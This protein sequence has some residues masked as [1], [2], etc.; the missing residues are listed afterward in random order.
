M[1]L[2]GANDP[3]A[4]HQPAGASAQGLT[5]F[6]DDFCPTRSEPG[7]CPSL[8]SILS[9]L[10]KM[11]AL[12][13][14]TD[15]DGAFTSLA[16][17]GLE[18]AGVVP[19]HYA[20]QPIEALF[21]AGR[22]GTGPRHAHLKALLGHAA[23]FDT[24][25]NGRELQ[26]H[27]E[28]LRDAGGTI[29]GVI[30]VALDLTERMAA[31]RAL[32]V[33]EQSYRSLIQEAPY[34]MC[35]CTLDGQLL[36]VNRAMVELLGY[37]ASCE[38]ELLVRDLDEIFAGTF[39]TL[40]N[41][42]L[43]EGTVN[44]METGWLPRDGD[45]VQV[46]VSGRAFRDRTGAITLLDIL[47]QNVTDK[48]RLEEHLYQAHK[49]QAI[50]QLA[51]GVAHDFNNLLTVIGGQV[52]LILEEAEDPLLRKRL[53]RIQQASERASKLTRQLLAYSR[54]QVMQTKVIP[55][56]EVIHHLLDLLSRLVKENVE[57]TFH[58]GHDLG[59]VRADPHQLEQVLINLTINAQDAMP[60]G[61]LLTLET[62]NL[63][64]EAQPAWSKEPLPPGDYVQIIV[65]DTGHGMAP[66]LQE[67]VFEPFF[68]TKH[69]GEGTGLG[70]SMAYGIVTQ[71]GGTISLAS[72]PGQGCTFWITLPRTSRPELE[73]ATQAPK[74][75]IPKG[76]ETILLAEDEDALRSLVTGYLT[77]LGYR[78]LE[79]PDGLAALEAA[80]NH[81]GGIHLLLTDLVM[82][83]AGGRML[84]E[85]MLKDDPELKVIF[86]S[87][88]AGHEVSRE[89]LDLPF[90]HFVAK[91][92]SMESLARTV[93]TV[94]DG[95]G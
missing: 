14:A 11:P 50:G 56:N 7:R 45:L 54:R 28:P 9:L 39:S 64:L 55:L 80:R 42:L 16:G 47:A 5:P 29:L 2:D 19:S 78:V 79:A 41:A 31:E 27:L 18:A 71:S 66:A 12:L 75:S 59:W 34:A 93:R 21:P 63:R 68:T 25:V 72:T 35:R 22:A 52:E 48:K 38:S 74:A 30:G 62:R 82:P 94:L 95:L 33:S 89:D 4:L 61:G 53:A 88:Y 57:L 51:G 32:R 26:A 46:V 90:G 73:P 85:E 36:Q 69:T 77:R 15:A 49:M 24:E 81:S 76:S 92:V 83:K 43:Q 13:W 87:G 10:Q 23:T 65:K 67:R 70:L 20:G 40:R 58:P 91:P 37:D 86:M 6:L 1:T 8:T 3:F 84:A 44:G 17:S 60:Q